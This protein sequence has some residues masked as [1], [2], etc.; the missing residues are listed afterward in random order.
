MVIIIIIKNKNNTK[1][2]KMIDCRI[3]VIELNLI[4]Y[5][6]LNNHL[7]FKK[8]MNNQLNKIKVKKIKNISY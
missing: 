1:M 5:W 3:L 8:G 6:Q 2:K 4:K 7:S